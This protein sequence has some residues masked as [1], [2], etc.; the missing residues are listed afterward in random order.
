MK[1]KDHSLD[2]NESKIK[3]INKIE[4]DFQTVNLGIWWIERLLNHL[5]K[6]QFKEKP[7]SKVKNALFA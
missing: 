2:N 7:L 1:D 5:Y 6:N 3:I 4:M